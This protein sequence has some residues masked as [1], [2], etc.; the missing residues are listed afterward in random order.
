MLKTPELEKLI[1]ERDEKGNTPLHLVAMHWRP[2]IV[3]S[4]TWDKRVQ[5]E[6]V[7]D[8][9]LTALDAA[10]KYIGTTPPFRKVCLKFIYL[11]IFLLKFHK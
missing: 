3:N 5:L 11:F 1:N 9:G 6:L 4:L 7:N 10:E 8:A 2:K